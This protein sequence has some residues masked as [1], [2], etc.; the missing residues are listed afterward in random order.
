MGGDSGDWWRV[1]KPA[2]TVGCLAAFWLWESWFPA[3]R[4][5]GSRWRHAGRN[6]AIALFNT[7]V[8]AL[9]F[10][11]LTVGVSQWTTEN[12]Y[13]LLNVLPLPAWGHLLGAIILL[14]GW[15]YVWH[16]LNHRVPFLWRFH[17]MHHSDAELDVT[18]ATRFHIGEHVGSA[19]LR[20][21][22]IPLFGVTTAEIL[23]SE[24]L[25]VAV[26]MFH[27]ANIS[28]RRLD[29][30]LRA[31]IVTPGM[32]HL[33]HS[34]YQ[35]ETDSN[36]AVLF[37]FWDRLARSYRGVQQQSPGNYGLDQFDDDRWQT[38]FGMLKTPLEPQR[39]FPSGYRRDEE[40][41]A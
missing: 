22:L 4:Y 40:G 27:H 16:R 36:Y 39:R 6:A 1:A 31:V 8:L 33:H 18:S 29:P 41:V 14:D 37:S 20:L 28:L 35:P 12:G 3:V 9:L 10:A 2:L 11:S 32:H 19:I 23:V 30:F 38:T 13:G 15:L 21:G 24:M 5:R 25:V 34:R 26:T 17:R 7:A